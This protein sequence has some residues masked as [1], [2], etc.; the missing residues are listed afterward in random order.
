M[1]EW[2]RFRLGDAIGIK[3]G[4]AFKGEYFSDGGYG[5]LLLTPGNFM[6][7]GGFKSGKPKHYLGP[8][9]PEFELGSGDL[10]V[11]MTDLSKSGDTLGYPAIIP[12]GQRYLHNQRIG[13]VTVKAPDR[14]DSLYLYY[15][16]RTDSY[17]RHVL[18]GATGS[19]VRHTSP[20]RISDYEFAAPTLFEQQVIAAALASFDDKITSNAR[21]MRT[22]DRLARAIFEAMF[23]QKGSTK[24]AMLGEL[25]DVIDCL[26]SRKPQ[27]VEGGCRYLVLEDIRD[28]SRLSSL[29]NFTISSEDYINWTRRIEAHEGDCLLTNVGRVGAVGQIPLG[30]TAAIGRNMT[31]IRGRMECP[32]AYLVEALRSAT[33]RREIDVKTDHGTVLSALN[34]RSIP[35]LL[36]PASTVQDRRAFQEKADGL[37]KLQDQLLLEN[38]RLAI[39]RD[40]LLPKLVSGEIR[41]RDAERV[42]EGAT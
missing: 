39:M 35:N 13:L 15:V 30:V 19:T 12:P 8:V 36:V 41:V 42:V 34:V 25:A 40:T 21:T 3:H 31:A 10:V 27:F 26:H 6:L 18:A 37:H 9:P 28:D 14:V 32:P 20:S 4:Y 2:Q 38:A 16:L 7:G 11:T 23:E 17:R 1:S 33:V 22:S 5:P 24:L 29:P